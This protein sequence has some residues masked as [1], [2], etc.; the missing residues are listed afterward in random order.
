MKNKTFVKRILWALPVI[1]IIGILFWWK[2]S[3]GQEQQFTMEYYDVFDTVTTVTGNAETE[4]I[5]R[6]QAEQLHLQLLKYHQLFDIYH[7][8]EGLT[9]VKNLNER[10]ATEAIKVDQELLDFL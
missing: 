7:T 1:I 9:N 4:E 5:F 3:G 6:E 8:Y 2:S 10:C